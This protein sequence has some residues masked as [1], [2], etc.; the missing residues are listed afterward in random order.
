MEETKS[1]T[2]GTSGGESPF[3]CMSQWLRLRNTG[4]YLLP[5]LLFSSL[6][7][8]GSGKTWR[9]DQRI[10]LQHVDTGGYLHSHDKKYSR[11]AGGQQE[12]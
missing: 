5:W 9:Q 1:Q 6:E 11:I 10:R 2:L 8:E 3:F 4:L 7:I 12:V